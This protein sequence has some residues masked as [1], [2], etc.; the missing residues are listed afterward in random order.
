MDE[1]ISSNM[2][3]A[4]LRFFYIYYGESWMLV[5][6]PSFP[7]NLSQEQL[8]IDYVGL[9]DIFTWAVSQT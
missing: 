5:H 4:N 3:A 2:R 8:Q 7:S 9:L 1:L 6:I